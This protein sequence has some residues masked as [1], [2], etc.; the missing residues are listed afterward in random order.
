MDKSEK[1]KYTKE[2]F[3]SSVSRWEQNLSDVPDFDIGKLKF[4]LTHSRNKTFDK[5]GMRAYK[6]LKAYKYFEE[7]YVQKIS[8][9]SIDSDYLIRAEVLA[10]MAQRSYQSFVCLDPNGNVKGGIC[11]CVAG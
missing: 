6:S 8:R 5:E 1:E 2:W 9:G 11:E 3:L 10:S 7:G 4:Y